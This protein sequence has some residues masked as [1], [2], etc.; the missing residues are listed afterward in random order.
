MENYLPENNLQLAEMKVS[1]LLKLV[2]SDCSVNISFSKTHTL[3]NQESQAKQNY[4]KQKRNR[5]KKKRTDFANQQYLMFVALENYVK[6]TNSFAVNRENLIDIFKIK[7][8]DLDVA[9]TRLRKQYKEI[10]DT[11]INLIRYDHFNELYIIHNAWD[12]KPNNY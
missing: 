11:R 8:K 4:P 9:L 1:D 10:F 2:N 7:N 6:A 12:L 3:Q 5:I